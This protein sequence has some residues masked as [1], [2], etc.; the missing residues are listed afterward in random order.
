MEHLVGYK[1]II[2]IFAV[3]NATSYISDFNQ[4]TPTVQAQ[5]IDCTV[6]DSLL[7]RTPPKFV[8]DWEPSED[9]FNTTNPTQSDAK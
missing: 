4:N 3:M 6:F 2:D 9:Y 5:F 8:A 1:P 7:L